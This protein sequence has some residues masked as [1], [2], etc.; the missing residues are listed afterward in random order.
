MLIHRCRGWPL[1]ARKG[2]DVKLPI[3]NVR[4]KSVVHST[5][6]GTRDVIPEFDPDCA[7]LYASHF[8]TMN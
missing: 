4:D 2:E 7:R 1:V 8:R 3:P 6:S 5:P